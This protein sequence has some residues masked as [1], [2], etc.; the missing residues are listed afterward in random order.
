LT[1]VEI[2]YNFSIQILHFFFL[3]IHDMFLILSNY[4]Y[5]KVLF[6]CDKLTL[7]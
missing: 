2:L 7:Q 5:G 1:L 3:I 4:D 6:S